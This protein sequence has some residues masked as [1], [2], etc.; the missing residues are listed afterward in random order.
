MESLSTHIACT[1]KNEHLP[2]A[3]CKV[4]ILDQPL[5][6]KIWLLNLKLLIVKCCEFF[7]KQCCC[8]MRKFPFLPCSLSRLCF[9]FKYSAQHR[10]A[11]F[12]QIQLCFQSCNL[13]LLTVK[14]PVKSQPWF[15]ALPQNILGKNDRQPDR[16][17]E[18]PQS[19][20]SLGGTFECVE[21]NQG[22]S[23]R[24][25]DQIKVSVWT[26]LARC[27][28]RSQSQVSKGDGPGVLGRTASG[29]CSAL[30]QYSCFLLFQ[31]QTLWLPKPTPPTPTPLMLFIWNQIP[32]DTELRRDAVKLRQIRSLI[33][34][35]LNRVLSASRRARSANAPIT[36]FSSNA[37]WAQQQKL[38]NPSMWEKTTGQ[39]KLKIRNRLSLWPQTPEVSCYLS[40]FNKVVSDSVCFTDPEN[41]PS[42]NHILSLSLSSSQRVLRH[43]SCGFQ[44]C[45]HDGSQLGRSTGFVMVKLFR[46]SSDRI[47]QQLFWG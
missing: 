14:Y 39:Q 20:A 40:C 2:A 18:D 34:L 28:P 7:I 21:E 5:L 47:L 33:R 31:S 30:C 42:Y 9:V 3:Q 26:A 15:S 4:F 23:D 36:R 13:S 17:H 25:R 12:N 35:I 44:L 8:W 6:Q 43:S 16:F 19:L 32:S 24:P 38:T 41:C 46:T 45:P 27:H 29:W 11:G 22:V 37:V 10:N 1:D